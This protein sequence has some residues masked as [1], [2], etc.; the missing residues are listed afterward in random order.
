M[1]KLLA[2]ILALCL[3]LSTMGTL[4]FA[5]GETTIYNVGADQAYTDL[6]AALA[7][8]TEEGATNVE[9]HIY[10]AVNLEIPATHGDFDFNNAM[11]VGENSYAKVTVVGGGVSEITNVN[12]KN[13]TFADEGTYNPTANEFMYQNFAGDCTFTNVKF[14]DGIRL[15]TSHIGTPATASFTDCVFEGEQNN[16]YVVWFDNGEFEM[17]NCNLTADGSAYGIVKTETTKLDVTGSTFTYTVDCTSTKPVFNFGENVDVTITNNT[18]NSDDNGIFEVDSGKING[19]DASN[20]DEVE[21]A[22]ASVN[23]TTEDAVY[24]AMVNT[25]SYTSLAAALADAQDGDIITLIANVTEDVTVG[26]N[27]TIDGADYDYT[28]TMT[29]VTS[30]TVTIQNVNFVQG[31]ITETKGTH[32]KLTVKDCDFD[33]VDNSIGYAITVRGS[34]NVVIEGSTAMNYGYGM[35]YIPSSVAKINVKDVGVSNVAAAFNISY[36]GDGEF[37]DVQ[38]TNATYGLHIQNHG[39][40][41]FTL[42]NCDFICA[43]PVFVQEKGTAYV[44]FSFE[45]VNNLGTAEFTPSSYAILN[46]VGIDATVE[47]CSGLNIASKENYNVIYENGKYSIECVAEIDGVR[48]P[49]FKDAINAAKNGDVIKL[50]RDVEL[51]ET[52]NVEAGDNIVLDLNGKTIY[53]TH[54]TDYSMIHVLNGAELTVKD[55]SA[56]QNGKIT[57]AAGGN[58]IGAAVWVEGKLTLES[59]TI[60]VTGSWILGFAV[61]LRPNAWG[62]AHTVGA[63]FDMNGGTVNSTDTAVRVASNSSDSY[64]ELGVTFTMNGGSIDSDWDAIF[65]QHLYASDLNVNVVSGTVS[66]DN[67]AMRIYGDAG[68]DIDMIVTGGNFEGNIKVADA[69]INTDAIAISGGTFSTDPSAYVTDNFQASRTSTGFEVIDATKVVDE[70]DVVFANETVY[71]DDG[72]VTYDIVLNG[73]GDTINRLNSVELTFDLPNDKMAYEVTAAENISITNGTSNDHYMFYF[74]G[75]TD[76]SNDSGVTVKIGQIKVTG[77]GEYTLSVDNNGTNVA[78]ATTNSDNLVDSFVT[79][80]EAG[81]GVL[82]ITNSSVNGTIAVPTRE[83]TVKVTFPN[84]VVD[85]GADYQN[86]KVEITGNIDG[87]NQTVEY[88]LGDGKYTVT[89]NRL[90]LHEAYTVTVSG[91]GYRTA[92]YTVTMTDDKTLNFWNNVMDNAMEVEEGKASSAAFKNFLAGDIVAD[93]NINIYDLSAVVSYFTQ[94]A[95][96]DAKYIKYDL[97]RDGVIDSK[98]VAYVLV[99]WGE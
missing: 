10:G 18:F 55:T 36:S 4:A 35:L 5:D 63:F 14:I 44:T 2:S 12:M 92:R 68:S 1:K 49:F 17:T 73:N 11:V 33:G 27:I 9:Y 43:N 41:T 26:N 82:D 50:L 65:V 76:V 54:G 83:L 78:H 20:S 77:Y 56:E 22:L 69:Y 23:I 87:V 90:V 45:G 8:A 24:V 21:K 52:L 13:L 97:N 46:L 58:N 38:V 85:N 29:V 60:E 6:N 37:E 16:E 93:N 66:G 3:V 94:D 15:G 30:K 39:A 53:G 34:D 40:R 64:P 59:G 98:D 47:A 74:K 80:G 51:K 61:D 25:I 79:T 28:G 81:K 99:S 88:K 91:D 7:K 86:M 57:C 95:T 32:G 89:E 75:K 62:T 70:I 71:A 96:K 67:S 48:Y 42:N 72:Y 84:A 19:V 31:C